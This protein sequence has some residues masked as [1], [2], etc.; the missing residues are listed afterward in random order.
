MRNV[1]VAVWTNHIAGNYISRSGCGPTNGLD[2][3]NG[4]R[5]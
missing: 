1:L 3:C 2:S 4:I 5:S